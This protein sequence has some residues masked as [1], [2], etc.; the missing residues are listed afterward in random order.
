MPL[1]DAEFDAPAVGLTDAEFDSP[2]STATTPP[3]APAVAETPWRA[4]AYN[5][6]PRDI[7]ATGK[8]LEKAAGYVANV[9]RAIPADVAAG[10]SLFKR[11]PGHKPTLLPSPTAIAG[12]I[13]QNLPAAAEASGNIPAA[14][15][16]EEMP[17]DAILSAASREDKVAA[18]IGKISQGLAATAPMAAI[19]ALPAA[20][21]KL[22]LIGFT[23]K[24]MA[25]APEIATQ[26]GDELGKPEDQRDPDKLTTLISDAI[27]VTGFSIL[28][29]N[30]LVRSGAKVISDY[31]DNLTPRGQ[32]ISFDVSEFNELNRLAPQTAQAI[33]ETIKTTEVPSADQIPKTMEVAG[34]A[35]TTPVAQVAEGKAAQVQPPPETL[36]PATDATVNRAD[37]SGKASELESLQ[38]IRDSGMELTPQQQARLKGFEASETI[39][40]GPGAASP[41]DFPTKSQIEQLGSAF[42][43]SETQ[44]Q[45]VT[46]KVKAIF[47][48]ENQ[49]NISKDMLS[50][51]LSALK[52]S[53]NYLIDTWKGQKDLDPLLKSK[54]I[55]SEELE[56][57]G[58]RMRQ[59]MKEMKRTVPDVRLREAI[60]K[61]VDAGWDMAKLK[62]AADTVPKNRRAPY[63]R[64]I[65]LTPQEKVLAGHVQ[66][67]FESR[68][69]EAIDAGVL[70]EGI[71]DY[72]HRIYPKE[73]DWKKGIVNAVQNGVLDTRKPGL[74]MKRVFELD[75][76]AEKAG[77]NPVNDFIPRVLDYEASLAK[78]ISSRAA[79]KRFTE[80]T[81]PDGRPLLDVSGIGV[82]VENS[83]GVRE[84]TLIKPSFKP[85]EKELGPD[86]KP[87]EN[88]RQDYQSRDYSALKKWKWATKDGE[89]NPIFVE[90][91]VLI[92][93]DAVH[94]ID[95]LLEPSKVRKYAAGRAVLGVSSVFKQ[96]MLD[97]SGFHQVQI[98]IHGLEHKVNP[99]NLVREIDFENP[100]VSGLLRGGVTLGG[101]H[102]MGM[103]Q[104]GL[105]GRSLSRQIPGIGPLMRTY[106]EWLFQDFI[107]RVKMTMALHA[108]ERN[109]GRFKDK[110]ASGELTEYGLYHQTAKEANA[111]FGGLNYIML[112]RS[113]TAQDMARMILL[114]PDFLEAR[115]RFAAQAGTKLG[116]EQRMALFLGALTMYTV[117]RV[118]NKILDDQYHFEPENAFSIVH[119]GKAYS[120]RTVQ[121]DI[122]HAV[123]EPVRF[124]LHRLNPAV[125]RPLLQLLTERDAFGR[126]RTFWQTMG[127]TIANIV[128]I[129]MRSSREQKLFTSLLNSFGG[130]VRRYSEVRHIYEKAQEWKKKNGVREEPGEFIYDPDKDVY[131]PLKLAILD[132][133]DGAA[134]EEFQ[135]LIKNGVTPKQAVEH[136]RRF[137]T[138]PFTGSRSRESKF[139]ASL[140]EDEK[141]AYDGARQEKQRIYKGFV[142]AA[143]LST[144]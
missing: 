83:V 124:W 45:S 82:P 137:A 78:V 61:Y 3:P 35:R 87:T 11:P 23:A 32:G 115:G 133:D 129:S 102:A 50:R 52:D 44:K 114:A 91:N 47:D 51:S 64:A 84:A 138:A 142:K 53:G 136:F 29:A 38:T 113:K 41:T 79:V 121:G 97:F 118:M 34:D 106:H 80:I 139:K 9:S 135:K 107:P 49:K 89:G 39:S 76:E 88:Y 70:K 6:N 19:A 26:L 55:L 68:L 141:K 126:K 12:A 65:A 18:T 62:D 42:K 54:G 48:I 128:P 57:R 105:I 117:A 43:G 27:Q 16:G 108:L 71:E 1:T 5:L 103:A 125:T 94:R 74:A 40:K 130:S 81:M 73:T 132:G 98:A 122:L 7:A 66:S 90:G 86:G 77:Y 36:T 56:S 15:A 96:T 69:Q 111:A 75:S 21:Q 104:E 100:N 37:T 20:A 31:A 14:L 72:I 59:A 120:I 127:D 4:P 24:M 131:R 93:P 10:L 134:T 28:G 85:G 30:H 101:E 8:E 95:A 33:A 92:H 112:E 63:D 17:I 46:E 60:S 67:Y 140:S 119:D 143:Q 58:W 22:A 144:P 109:R 13:E 99:F 123:E 2:T 116:G 25:D 110:L